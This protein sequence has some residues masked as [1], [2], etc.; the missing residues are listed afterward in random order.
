MV[1][2]CNQDK[3]IGK[4]AELNLLDWDDYFELMDFGEMEN[5]EIEIAN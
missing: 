2:H 3:T 4:I 5:Y 1:I